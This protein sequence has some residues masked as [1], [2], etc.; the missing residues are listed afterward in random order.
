MRTETSS[1]AGVNKERKVTS[2]VK[3]AGE[4]KKVSNMGKK[5]FCHMLELRNTRITSRKLT[6]FPNQH[7]QDTS[8]KTRRKMP[9]MM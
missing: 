7:C 3:G 9:K 6:T 2:N 5:I 8:E 1:E 4:K